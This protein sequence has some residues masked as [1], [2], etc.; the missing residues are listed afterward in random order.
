MQLGNPYEPVAAPVPEPETW[1]ML[2][3]GLGLVGMRL[4]RRG[5]GRISR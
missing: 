3:S 1:A 2:V 4:R 5:V